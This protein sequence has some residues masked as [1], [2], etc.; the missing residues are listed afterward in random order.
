MKLLKH[1]IRAIREPF[2]TAGLIVAVVALVAALAGG[3]YAAS[4]GL[5]GK[6]K[7]EVEKI[8]K[9]FAGAPGVTGAAG[10]TGPAGAPG[11]KGD[12]GAKGDK[13]D[14]GTSGVPGTPGA[15][16]KNVEVVPI[17][18]G[19]TACG[20]RG[21]AFLEVAESEEAQEVC[22]GL[23]GFA[24]ELPPGATETG[25]Y[26]A[27]PATQEQAESPQSTPIRVPISFP[28]P[29]PESE[30]SLTGR[31]VEVQHVAKGDSTNPNCPGSFTEP[32]AKE[33]FMCVYETKSVNLEMLG[34]VEPETGVN[35]AGAGRNG[36]TLLFHP[37]AVNGNQV[38]TWAVTAR[39]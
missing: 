15:D 14:A 36:V 8:A 17:A 38:G 23:S 37:L 4:G 22:N 2:G 32:K 27:G 6:Q 21:G 24:T 18:T 39:K 34:E 7:K 25:S 3:A 1:P 28:F 5:S 16:G 9:K 12:T 13:G 29:L 20:G 19:E 10:P 35:G 26:Y 33:G 30:G 31:K 11:A